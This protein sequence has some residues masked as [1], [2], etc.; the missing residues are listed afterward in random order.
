MTKKV[1]ALRQY[2]NSSRSIHYSLILVLPVLAIYEFGLLI[3]FKNSF[4]E[5][6]NSGEIL[7]RNLFTTLKLTNPYL[8]SGILLS[9]FAIVMIRGYKQEKQPGIHADYIVYML[10]ES[11][12]WGAALFICLTLFM[13]LPLQILTYADKVA[14]INLAIGAG[15]FEELIFRMVVISAIFVILNR[16]LSMS[17]NYSSILAIITAACIFAAFHLL[18]ESY[19]FPIF[20]QRVGGGIFLG[21][22]YTFR[23]YGI[24]VYTHIIYNFLILA[25][26]W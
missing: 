12:V 15:I 5:L 9:I 1:S 24:S 4:F 26:T 8:V 2:L 10:L 17:R 3:L 14:N 13:Q 20:A 25:N 11:M 16:G 23:G 6:R 7:L 19:S 21:V 18:M 22:L